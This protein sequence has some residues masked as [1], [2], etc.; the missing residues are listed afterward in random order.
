MIDMTLYILG[1][2]L[3]EGGNATFETVKCDDPVFL[4][5]DFLKFS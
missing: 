5:K 3:K 1:G 2:G 4:K